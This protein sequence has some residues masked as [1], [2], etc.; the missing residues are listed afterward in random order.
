M[1]K[2][3]GAAKP[4]KPEKTDEQK[5]LQQQ[6]QQHAKRMAEERGLDWKSIP[7][8]ERKELKRSARQQ[9]KPKSA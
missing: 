2:N 5:E 7:Q 8:E 4:D 1:P 3:K 6:I 9:L